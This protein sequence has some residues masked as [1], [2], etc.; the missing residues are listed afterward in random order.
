[1]SEKDI[2]VSLTITPRNNTGGRGFPCICAKT[3]KT[4]LISCWYV[5]HV[6]VLLLFQYII[7]NNKL[8]TL[9]YTCLVDFY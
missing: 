3:A 4:V 1:M 7:V 2:L 8:K 5:L 9:I 6:C